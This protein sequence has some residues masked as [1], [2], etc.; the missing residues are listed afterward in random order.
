MAYNRALLLRW[1]V[2][3]PTAVL[4]SA[5][6]A[7]LFLGRREWHPIIADFQDF[8]HGNARTYK[9]G[10]FDDVEIRTDPLTGRV[11]RKENKT[12]Q[13]VWLWTYDQNGRMVEERRPD[14]S[15]RLWTYDDEGRLSGYQGPTG[16][17]YGIEHAQDGTMHARVIGGAGAAGAEAATT[18]RDVSPEELERITPPLLDANGQ[19]VR[20]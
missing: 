15:R 11:I 6:V 8:L 10:C 5:I 9:D 3:L 20:P 1:A 19:R 13:W 16:T 2:G 18:E 4:V 17:V 14:S 12:R 7:S